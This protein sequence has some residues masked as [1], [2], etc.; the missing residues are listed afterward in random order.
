MSKEAVGE[1]KKWKAAKR[2]IVRN[3]TSA[4]DLGTY[5]VVFDSHES[6]MSGGVNVV[7]S[8]HN[9]LCNAGFISL[10]LR[11]TLY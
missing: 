4:S 5:T 9:C 1:I 3:V 8:E 11:S 7:I 2:A 6:I 10:R